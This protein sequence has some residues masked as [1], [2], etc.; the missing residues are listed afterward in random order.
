MEIIPVIDL[1]NSQVVR[2]QRGERGSYQPIRSSLCTSS[3]PLEVIHGLL[4][5]YPFRSLYIADLD[6]ILESGDNFGIVAAVREKFPSMDLW[7]DAGMRQPGEMHRA[8]ELKIRPVIGSERLETLDQYLRLLESP[9]SD[10]AVLSLD[11][12]HNGFLGPSGLLVQA[13]L[14]PQQVICMTL[15]RV[16]SYGGPESETLGW[17]HKRVGQRRLFAAGG[18]RDGQD[19]SRLKNQ[20]IAGALVASALHDGK[21]SA[22]QLQAFMQ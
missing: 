15:S 19:V 13:E 3:D 21:I 1:L 9:G 18:I 14:W 17:L 8:M 22:A 5:L 16:G 10:G 4:E 2:A 11:F 7:V 20:G 12:G 6:A